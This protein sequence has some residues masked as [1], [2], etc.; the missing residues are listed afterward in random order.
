MH[1]QI[2]KSHYYYHKLI[3]PNVKS[4]VGLL[5]HVL[6]E[7]QFVSLRPQHSPTMKLL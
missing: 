1:L 5:D 4:H 2:F 6:L 3:E 7:Q